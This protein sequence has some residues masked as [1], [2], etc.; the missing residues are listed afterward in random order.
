MDSE[1]GP[2]VALFD[3]LLVVRD[4]YFDAL[5]VMAMYWLRIHSEVHSSPANSLMAMMV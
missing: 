5:T 3:V 4:Q 1:F 2:V